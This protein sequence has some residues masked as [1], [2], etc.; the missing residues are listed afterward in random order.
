MWRYSIDYSRM[1]LGTRTKYGLISVCQLCGRRG[2]LRRSPTPRGGTFENWTH[3]EQ[4]RRLLRTEI[5]GCGRE[6]FG[7]SPFPPLAERTTE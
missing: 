7:P 3:L 1:S 6:I 4:G 2:A 5:Q